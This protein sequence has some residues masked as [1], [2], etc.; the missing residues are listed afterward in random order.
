MEPNEYWEA[1]FYERMNF[2]KW[3]EGFAIINNH[4]VPI[5]I[6]FNIYFTFSMN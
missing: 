2:E 6:F 3:F 5:P 1:I 4:Y